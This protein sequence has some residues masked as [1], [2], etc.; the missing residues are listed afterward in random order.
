MFEQDPIGGSKHRQSH[1]CI[2]FVVVDYWSFEDMRFNST[3]RCNNSYSYLKWD[4]LCKQLELSLLR[5]HPSSLHIQ[6]FSIVSLQ[7]GFHPDSIHSNSPESDKLLGDKPADVNTSHLGHW[8]HEQLHAATVRLYVLKQ[9]LTHFS[10]LQ[11][12]YLPLA[13]SAHHL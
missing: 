12:L 5:K 13:A 9:Q 1:C 11:S 8:Q 3:I 7:T 6:P 10:L 2:W 4:T